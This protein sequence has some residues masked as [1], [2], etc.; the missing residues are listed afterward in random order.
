AHIHAFFQEAHN[1]EVIASLLDKGVNWPKVA[2][3]TEGLPLSG[4]T[5]VLT[6]SL[7]SLTRDEAA[8]RLRALG[9][10]VAG[11]VSKNTTC[12]VAGDKAGSKLTKAQSLGVAIL[13]E[14][15]LLALLESH[16]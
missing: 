11:S 4:Q 10:T 14:A 8:D 12:V 15:G 5:W 1:R 9:A 3:R 6:G 13:D 7:T 2:R 16:A